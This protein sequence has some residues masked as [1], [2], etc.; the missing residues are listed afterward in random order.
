MRAAVLSLPNKAWVEVSGRVLAIPAGG[1]GDALN[2]LLI[3]DNQM[4]R[5]LSR[6]APHLTILDTNKPRAMARTMQAPEPVVTTAASWLHE[7]R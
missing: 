6:L 5:R 1:L 3:L 4:Q 2:G 7:G